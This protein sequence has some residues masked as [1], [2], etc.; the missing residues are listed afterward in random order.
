MGGR[1]LECLAEDPG[2]DVVAQQLF[3]GAS[4]SS[5]N[6]NTGWGG[7]PSTLSVE[8][9][10]DLFGCGGRLTL[11]PVFNWQDGFEPTADNHY[12]N[13]VGNA[14]YM[15][16]KGFQYDP[17]RPVPRLEDA[18][19]PGPSKE[20]I[21]PGKVYHHT[22]SNGLV[23]RYWRYADPG[24]FGQTTRIRPD[25]SWSNLV[26]PGDDLY[27][28]DLIG[29][30]VYFRFG[31][32]SFGGFITGWEC[33]NRASTPTFSVTL[34]SA[35]SLLKNCKVIVSKYAGS[36]FAKMGGSDIVGGPTNYTGY[37]GN[38]RG[39]LKE[40]NLANVFNVY[41]FLESYGFGTSNAN[42]NGIP[43]SYILNGLSVL[44]AVA[45]PSVN[46]SYQNNLG[47]LFPNIVSQQNNN[48]KLG[49]HSAFSPFGRILSPCMMTDSKI[50]PVPFNPNNGYSFGVMTPTID[51]F[52][53]PRVEF[54]LDL[55]EIPR[56]PLDV[57]YNGADGIASISD[58]IEEACE[59]TGRD[60]YTVMIRK[61]G[62]NFIKVKTVDR[63]FSVPTN[64]IESVVKTLESA[65]PAIPVTNSSFGKEKNDSATPRV[66]YIGANQQRLFQT[67]SYLLGYSNTHL[68][69]HHILKKFVNYYRLC[70]TTTDTNATATPG[71]EI[72]SPVAANIDVV[73]VGG[74]T[75]ADD[76]R[77]GPTKPNDRTDDVIKRIN[78][79]NKWTNSYRIP[80]AYSTRNLLLSNLLNGPIVTELFANEQGIAEGSPAVSLS[81]FNSIFNQ[82]DVYANDKPIGGSA[83]VRFGNYWTT[84]T[85]SMCK[86]EWYVDTDQL[87]QLLPEECQRSTNANTSPQDELVGQD[88]KPRYIPLKYS[89][90]C[91]FFGYANDQLVGDN[92]EKGSN[93]Y[94]FVRPVY[95]DTWSGLIN[96]GFRCNELPMLSLGM[97]PVWYAKH[98]TPS[99][100]VIAN[101]EGLQ[102]ANGPAE[103]STSNPQDQA[104][105]DPV[106]GDDSQ[107]ELTDEEKQKEADQNT[108]KA[109]KQEEERKKQA[110]RKATFTSN[111]YNSYDI[112]N[113]CFLITESELRAAQ[114]G[115]DDYLAYCLMKMQYSKPHLFT[116]L[117]KYYQSRGKLTVHDTSKD[118]TLQNTA[119]IGS[120]K[121]P[122]GPKNVG[123]NSDPGVV[124]NNQITAFDALNMNFNWILNPDFMRDWDRIT[125][126]VKKIADTYYGKQYLVKLPT[127]LSYRDYQYADLQLPVLADTELTMSVYQG[128]NKIF[129]NYEITDS[130]W[131]ELGNYIDDSIIVGSP[132]YYKLC[133]E[134]GR[135]PAIVGYNANPVKDY[136]AEKWC[137]YN[138]VTKID[139]WKKSNAP[140]AERYRKLQQELSN[141]GELGLDPKEESE[142]KGR[143]Q[144]QLHKIETTAIGK[145][146]YDCSLNTVPSLDF[147]RTEDVDH[148]L[149]M[150]I[151][152]GREDAYSNMTIGTP[153]TLKDGDRILDPA[154]GDAIYAV[155]LVDNPYTENV[156]EEKEVITVG[157]RQGIPT[158]KAYFPTSCEADFVFLD[159]LG[160]NDPRAR[161]DAPGMDLYFPSLSYTEDPTRTV[162]ANMAAE[163]YGILEGMKRHSVTAGKK[164]EFL[165]YIAKITENVKWYPDGDI[166][167]ESVDKTCQGYFNLK[168]ILLGLFSVLDEDG[169][170]L[171][172][173]N[174]SN[175]SGKY[176]TLAARKAHPFFAAV[177]V[178]DNISCYGPW[179]NYPL[180]A[181]NRVYSGYSLN[182]RFNLIEQMINNT[183]V[184]RNTE[185]CPWNYGGMSFLD[186]EIINQIDAKAT[187]QMQ[188]ENGMLVTYGM[189]MFNMSAG[190]QIKT[191]DS[192][193]YGF[194]NRMYMNYIYHTVETSRFFTSYA[195]LT[196]TNI[197]TSVADRSIST[198]YR[199]QTYSPKLGLFNKEITDRNKLAAK[200]RIS[201]LT[202][203]GAKLR[204]IN[205]KLTSTFYTILKENSQPRDLSSGDG[206]EMKGKYRQTSPTQYLV[207][208]ASYLIPWNGLP[209]CGDPGLN[210]N[211][212][213]TLRD[214]V[215]PEAY[216]EEAEYVH[217]I[218]RTKNWVG[219][220]EVAESLAELS[221][222]YNS[223]SLMSL[224]GIFSPVSFYPTYNL[225]TYP[226][227]SRFLST[228]VRSSGVT[229]PMCNGTSI[230]THYK[231][232]E[233]TPI[234]YPCP[235][236]NRPKLTVPT[237]E[238]D[239]QIDTVPE[240]N[241]KSLNPIIVP[242][243][244]FKNPNSQ[245]D[246]NP[247]ER[248]RHNI[249]VV[250]RQERPLDGDTSMDTG[251][252]LAIITNSAGQTNYD[253]IDKE[254][255]GTDF[256]NFYNSDYYEY[257]LDYGS[258]DNTKILLN[259][260]FF[261]FRGPMM[262]HGWGYDTDGYPVPNLA[263]QPLEFDDSGRPKRFVLTAS[264]TNDYEKDGKFL[265]SPGESLGDIIGSGYVKEDGQWT[266]K[267]TRY[268]HLNWGERSDLW[269]IGPIDLRWD[270]ERKVWTGGGGCGE[271]DPP[272]IMASGSDPSVLN[273]FVSKAKSASSKKCPYKMVYLVLEENLFSDIGMTDSYPARAFLDDSEYGLEPL[274]ATVRRLVYVKDKCGYS[275]PRGA[276][277]LCRYN[278]ETGFYEP[279]SKPSFTVFGTIAG[280]NNTAV[281]E[282]TYIRG[283]KAG[284]SAP[285]TNISFDNTRFNFNINASKSRRGM[286][287]FENG[288]WIL[289]GFN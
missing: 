167:D 146:M 179:T 30:P 207:G 98:G 34:N 191:T 149:V 148:V 82:V 258:A 279:I 229:C 136:V 212:Y 194:Y 5:F 221:S 267:P 130:A 156:D 202:Q 250:G 252:N 223:K 140:E 80:M 217:A 126:F 236:C 40:G 62:Y 220:F 280:G 151:D 244:E 175:Q 264:G 203:L 253:V 74:D 214:N 165:K 150:G 96:I 68:V 196:L 180:I 38:Y 65:S 45:D 42:D 108:A 218:C 35:E 111:P 75:A 177:P 188:L 123:G 201:F 193:V 113:V 210:S 168:R 46:S 182:A 235:M 73:V 72:Q 249:R 243:G 49:Y 176:Y 185:W 219:A 134:D 248:S 195:G 1:N 262:L 157:N 97:L 103:G 90:V 10:N 261:A 26:N 142:K 119:G 224:D 166:I 239:F 50:N 266:R 200:L 102:S 28:Y 104:E 124:G 61:G 238:G 110:A 9:V 85:E 91:P 29:A 172:E 44:T 4:I 144:H 274:P 84:Y 139:V 281:V 78:K 277:L 52:G 160:L 47:G 79:K 164:L 19:T 93:I 169:F 133:K 99:G 234:Q 13:C 66:M 190:L 222:Q 247:F 36:V 237:G 27:R 161:I 269:P 245:I 22:A 158:V 153:I 270:R 233:K 231:G 268:F 198:S 25:G 41:G 209:Y 215:V 183:D 112:K 276:K 23:S 58:I 118:G 122:G 87:E 225:G 21:V 89:S 143:L 288:K 246:I 69:Y 178:Q 116:M 192:D 162:I 6:S 278:R 128:S 199:F 95:L 154:T 94:K 147:S 230:H 159:P 287:L 101:Q 56:P 206:S 117:V 189:P 289:T 17:N 125:A 76:T 81:A 173:N 137:S 138:Q 141:L 171:L 12:Y 187:Y 127:V 59:K 216:K 129:F 121:M 105:A 71:L 186:R 15:D 70:E 83:V 145:M 255:E 135:I 242:L 86:P 170:L 271:I 131:E 100:G 254:E 7:S 109:K 260:R 272:Y 265:P 283:I 67:K 204:E 51:E 285:T 60:W 32:F 197:S 251:D 240:V 2:S 205:N 259:Q 31:Y 155:D 114:S 211:A 64:T 88:R 152:R 20:K 77:P 226:V 8:L 48:N 16:E 115:K 3:L 174:T 14:C 227:S 256:K 107:E 18:N 11:D 275:A 24:F 284:E 37:I 55:S 132:D 273:N 232:A 163:D 213:K 43:L 257:D 184:Q 57:R 282:L 33:N 228:T 54:L 181:D 92:L 53:V 106:V 241:F 263:D 208:S 39:L 286:F 63:T 120:G